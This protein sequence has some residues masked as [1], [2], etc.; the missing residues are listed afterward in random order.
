MD[1]SDL[2]AQLPITERRAYLFSGE[3]ISPRVEE[4]TGRCMEALAGRGAGLFDLCRSRGVD[5]GAIGAARVD[6]HGRSHTAHA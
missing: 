2:R 5:I 3:R 1:L 6:P 4:P